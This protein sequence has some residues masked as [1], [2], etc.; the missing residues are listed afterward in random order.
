MGVK[1]SELAEALNVND[2]DLL[3][4]VQNGETKKVQVQTLLKNVQDEID[5]LNNKSV[6]TVGLNSDQTI[7]GTSAVKVNLD[8]IT[9]STGTKLTFHNNSIE[10]GSGVTRVL[11]TAQARIQNFTTSALRRISIFRN[12]TEVSRSVKHIDYNY[13]TLFLS[14]KLINVSEGDVIALYTR[15]EGD[16]T[17]LTGNT[18]DTF[19]TVEVI[20]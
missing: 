12:N 16:S 6:Y 9:S 5:D 19:M 8:S 4:L 13:E 15:N 1:I 11:V 18:L 20:K 3:P 14:A 2:E 7:T 10:I 17:T